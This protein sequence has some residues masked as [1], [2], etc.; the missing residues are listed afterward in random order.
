MI[1]KY[2]VEGGGSVVAHTFHSSPW[3]L[4]VKPDGGKQL[5][6][7][8]ER[9][10]EIRYAQVYV[11]ELAHGPTPNVRGLLGCRCS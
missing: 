7:E 4:S 10:G 9:G 8:A 3:Y 6:V 11:A 2:G 5:V 1:A